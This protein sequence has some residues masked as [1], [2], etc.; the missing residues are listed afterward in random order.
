MVSGADPGFM[1]RGFRFIMGGIDLLILPHFSRFPHENE[2]ISSER[3]FE[4]TLC[5]RNP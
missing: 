4:Q 1:E 3:G 5:T 2:I